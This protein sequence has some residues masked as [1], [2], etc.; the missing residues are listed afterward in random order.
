MPPVK[1]D[2]IARSRILP[3]LAAVF[4]LIFGL[5]YIAN[6]HPVGDGL[7]YWYATS[8]R[9]DQKL[10]SDLHF[11]LQPFFVLLTAAGQKM[12]GSGWLASKVMPSIQLAAFVIMLRAIVRRAPWKPWERAVLLL[13]V[14][15]I[16]IASSFFRFDD[17]HITTNLFETFSL[18]LLLRFQERKSENTAEDIAIALLL[19]MLSGLSMA[20]RLNDGV[21]L[22]GASLLVFASTRRMRVLPLLVLLATSAAGLLGTVHL[23]GDT[24]RQW[25]DNSILKAAQIKGGAGH[26]FLVPIRLPLKAIHLAHYYPDDVAGGLCAVFILMLLLPLQALVVGTDARRR[27]GA[28]WAIGFLALATFPVILWYCNSGAFITP[29]SNIAVTPIYAVNLW[30]LYRMVLRLRGKQPANWKPQEMLFLIPFSQMLAAA[31]TAGLSM[32]LV[33]P[34]MALTLLLLP[35]SL[36]VHIPEGWPKRSVITAVCFLAVVAYP[37]KWKFPYHWHHYKS[38]TMF[39][40]RVLYRHPTLGPMYIETSQLEMIQPMCDHIHQTAKSTELLSLPYPYPN[41]FCGLPPWH[42]Y[43]QTWFDTSSEQ[44]IDNLDQEL[45]TNP[46]QWIVYQRALDTMVIH[47]KT[48]LNGRPLPHRKLDQLI[49]DKIK[50]G[51]WRIVQYKDFDDSDWFLIQTR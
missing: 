50:L 7:W 12:F 27:V 51:A 29:L 4:C 14:F 40:D 22:L 8:L 37:P 26:I 23:T 48:F 25:A 39:M 30:V 18:L 32:P 47:E 6:I 45:S 13:A 49:R 15:G 5:A 44:T 19:G 42:N 20:N 34:V 46:P 9:D 31:S 10:Y 35:V 28:L 38:G 2:V 21:A 1:P 36:P 24:F 16:M 11:N 43:V 3:E 41:Y 17:Y 33:T